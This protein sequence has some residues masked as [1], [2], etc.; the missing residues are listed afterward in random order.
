[1]TQ[2]SKKSAFIATGLMLFALFFGAGNLIYP[3]VL[4]QQAGQAVGAA[5]AGFL[6]TGVGL[7]LA[8]VLAVAYTGSRD[9]QELAGRVG[10]V[11]G[12]LF[13]VA[14]YLAIG[15]LFAA[16]RTATVSFDIG[17]RPFLGGGEHK[18]L[19]C[20]CRRLF[21][22]DLLA[23]DFARQTGRPRR[24]GADARAAG[25]DCRAGGLCGGQT[26]GRLAGAERGLCGQS[27]CQR[28]D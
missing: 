12:V 25:V 7:P 18:G 13:A 10:R 9:L 3:P 1:M 26:D 27:R 5:L 21:R 19:L 17:I 4:G 11:Y 20:V 14:L 28:F 6:L 22:A 2:T 15:P 16:P 24:Q 23:G 8:G